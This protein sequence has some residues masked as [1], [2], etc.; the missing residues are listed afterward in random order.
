MSNLTPK[1]R[2]ARFLG[3]TLVF[4]SFIFSGPL[5]ATAQ[6]P[7]DLKRPTRP[8]NNS[9]QNVEKAI[10]SAKLPLLDGAGTTKGGTNCCDDMPPEPPAPPGN[11]G[12]QNA[13]ESV[14]TAG[15]AGAIETQSVAEMPTLLGNYPNPFNPGTTIRYSLASTQHVQLAVYNLLGQKVQVLIDETQDAGLHEVRFRAET[16]PSGLYL[17]HIATP[18]GSFVRSMML[19]R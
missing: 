10:S 8:G 19:A 12:Y 13:A 6:K 15:I 18:T 17:A 4:A 14:H 5:P 7:S 2:A 11:G 1:S 3:T 16:L 9:Y